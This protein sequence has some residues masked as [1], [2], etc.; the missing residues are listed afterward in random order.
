MNYQ[1]FKGRSIDF[2]KEVKIYKNLHNGLW[3]VLQNGKV[4]AHVETFSIRGVTFKVSE[5]VRL[6]VVAER[7]K[8]VHAYIVGKLVE[9]N[10]IKRSNGLFELFVSANKVSYNPY[11]GGHFTHTS[12]GNLLDTFDNDHKYSFGLVGHCDF[13]ITHVK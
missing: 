7:K 6:K 3:S 9:V 11:K 1:A 2:T 8:Y 5:S 4:V 12:R 13:G 10:M